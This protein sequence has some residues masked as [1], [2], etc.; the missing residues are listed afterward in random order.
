MP[1]SYD[2]AVR[3]LLKNINGPI[4]SWNVSPVFSL[5]VHCFYFIGNRDDYEVVFT[6][7]MRDMKVTGETGGSASE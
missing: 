1:T 3:A 5:A 4:T 6:K 2:E 7:I